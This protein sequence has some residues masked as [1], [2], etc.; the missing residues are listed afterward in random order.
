MP[1]LW[2]LLALVIPGTTSLW[3]MPL[4]ILLLALP[5]AFALQQKYLFGL[6]DVE[7]EMSECES[8]NRQSQGCENGLSPPG[9]AAS[10]C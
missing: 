10:G 7:K 5:R 6:A 4:P 9:R 2:V 8:T 3:L 1:A